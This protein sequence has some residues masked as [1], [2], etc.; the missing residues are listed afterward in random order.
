MA[1]RGDPR[2][3]QAHGPSGCIARIGERCLALFLTPAIERGKRPPRHEDLAP[4]L[5]RCH[6]PGQSERN[7]PDRPDV[8]RHDLAHPPVATRDP[9]FEHAVAVM[10][11]DRQAVHLRLDDEGRIGLADGSHQ[12]CLPLTQ[13]VRPIGVVQRKQRAGVLGGLEAVGRLPADAQRRRIFGDQFG[14]GILELTQLALQS[15]VLGI[16]DFGVVVD[17]V[18][19]AMMRDE[20]PQ[21]LRPFCSASAQPSDSSGRDAAAKRL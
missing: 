19:L 5:E 9:A 7:R 20:P 12:P 10:D 17:V 6:R 3:E 16:G 11:R 14:V 21:L 18:A 13:L 15:V 1:R 4:N 8:G 2:V